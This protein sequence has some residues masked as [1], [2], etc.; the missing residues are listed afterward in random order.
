MLLTPQPTAPRLLTVTAR[1]LNRLRSFVTSLLVPPATPRSTAC[2][3][4]QQHLSAIQTTLSLP[5]T[6]QDLAARL[7][8]PVRLHLDSIGEL[9]VLCRRP[10]PTEGDFKF[11][12]PSQRAVNGFLLCCIDEGTQL[13]HLLV[14]P[15]EP[16]RHYLRLSPQEACRRATWTIPLSAGR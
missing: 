4:R 12:L 5:F 2:L 6:P 1:A 8:S 7:N 9:S 14:V 11:S 16:G 15:Q 13:L 3:D 10:H